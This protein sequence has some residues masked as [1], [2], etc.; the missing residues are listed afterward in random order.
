MTA[1]FGLDLG[2]FKSVS[3]LYQ[4]ATQEARYDTIDTDPAIL[5]GHLE[6]L[7]PD[8]VVFETCTV[9][10]WVADL[11]DAMGIARLVA[12]PMN[13]AW[14]WS[15]VKRKTD[16]DDALKL[17]RMAAL[18]ELPTAHVPSAEAR[19]YRGLVA[20]RHRLVGRRTA[21]QNHIRALC[22]AHGLIL[23]TAQKAW[24]R[25][26]R[27]LLAG[28]ARPLD[29]PTAAELWRGEL[30]WEL[31]ALDHIDALLTD[32]ESTLDRVGQANEHVRLLETI[33]GVGR[34]T[35]EVIAAYLDNPHRFR[36]AGEVSAYA[37][38]VPRQFQSGQTDRHGRITKR[39]PR[40][41]RAVLVESSWLVVRYNPWAARLFARLHRG[42]KSRR[43]PALV[44]VARKLL[45]RCWAM[46]RTGQ[47]WRAEPE[48]AAA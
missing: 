44:A 37:G 12:D 15:K 14:R 42:Q 22:Q 16:R 38:L 17:A 32:A 24:T 13:D 45:V 48:P 18:G 21:V 10:G 40:L 35:A 26:G 5:R 46:L 41:L 34:R 20:Y 1:I 30:A 39:G 6:R 11:C 43:K 4:P 2:K 23:P 8:L 28:I 31:S 33:P 47:P 29:A 36:T 3:C 9:A 7:R 19:Q 25:A 27:V